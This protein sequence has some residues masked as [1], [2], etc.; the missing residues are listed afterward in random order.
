[1]DG[2]GIDELIVSGTHLKAFFKTRGG[3]L[4]ELDIRSPAFNVTDTLT[5][6]KEIYHEKIVDAGN[7]SGSRP[8]GAVSIHEIS[9][10][11]ERDLERFL[12]YDVRNRESLLDHFIGAE[13]AL[14]DFATSSYRELGDFQGSDYGLDVKGSAGK[15]LFVFGRR[16]RVE[17][18]AVKGVTVDLVK[19]IAVSRTEPRIDVEYTLVPVDGGI[20]CRFAVENV[21][22][23]L[24]GDAPDRYFEFQGRKIRDRKLASSGAEDDVASLSLV[25]EWL[26]IEIGMKFSPA[27]LVWRFPIETV[28]NSE[29]GFER[30]YQGSAVAAL[31]PL[32]VDRGGEARFSISLSIERRKG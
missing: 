28:S 10:A 31:W 21:F 19:E 13:T 16:G 7:P 5:R 20:D 18:E 24:A 22:S 6:R 3:S 12:R 1:M 9:A 23:L 11:K 25:D 26:G 32:Q 2:D 8:D 4:R 15:P 17:S 29:S 30:V 14:D 27:A